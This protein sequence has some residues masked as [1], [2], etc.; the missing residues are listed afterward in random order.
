MKNTN[1]GIGRSGTAKVK[2]ASLGLMAIITLIAV[3]G[4][5]LIFTGCEDTVDNGIPAELLGNWRN[6]V[7]ES[8]VITITSNGKLT[9]TNVTYN[10]SVSGNTITVVNPDNSSIS[11]TFDYSLSALG[12]TMSLSNGTGICSTWPSNQPTLY[13]E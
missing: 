2:T 11:G 1:I 12:T 13:K 10:A 7:T 3:M 5:A 9:Y 6:P 8:L 4:F